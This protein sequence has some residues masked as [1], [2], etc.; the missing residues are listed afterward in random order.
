MS[1]KSVLIVEDESIVS[2]D[3]Q[4]CLKKLGYTIAGAC[5]KGEEAIT[6]AEETKPDVILMD[7][8]LKGDLNGIETAMK[9]NEK[10]SIPVI[11]LTAYADE[12]TVDKAKYSQPYGYIIK[13]F[14]EV[15][16]HSSIEV[17]LYKHS[18]EME[19]KKERDLLYSLV[20][21]REE[22]GVVFVKANSKMQKI[23]TKDI[24]FVEALKDYVTINTADQRYT[25]LSTMKNIE[26]RLSKKEF[27]R[28]HRSFI[29]RIDKI[30]AIDHNVLIMEESNRE[31]PVGGSYRDELVG[32]LNML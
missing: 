4:T 23:R 21:S 10:Q 3:I 7:I 25:I 20:E 9:I 11:Y 30:K 17:A 8:M 31:I 29:V 15:D 19:L 22:Q 27:L 14:K 16:L 12:N 18:K 13:P 26:E 24:Y 32:R 2:K 28:A 1:K 6:L 5:S